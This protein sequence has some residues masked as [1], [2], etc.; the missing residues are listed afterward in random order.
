MIKLLK[1]SFKLLLSIISIL[2]LS[3]ILLLG[4]HSGTQWL[5]N[6]AES[7]TDG[8]LT[9]QQMQGHL[10]GDFQ[11]TDLN[12]KDQ[13]IELRIN[14]LLFSWQPKKLLQG[15]VSVEQLIVASVYFEQHAAAK[16]EAEKKVE[17][18]EKFAFSDIV[19]PVDISL[20][21]IKISDI[22]I[23]AA[24]DAEPVLIDLLALKADAKDST[25]NIH[26]IDIQAPDISF[27]TKGEVSLVDNYPIA[28]N[29][30]FSSNLQELPKISLAGM[31]DGNFDKLTIK[32]SLQGEL[33]GQIN[34][35]LQQL[36]S[37]LSADI[38]IDISGN[39][40]YEQI[41]LLISGQVDQQLDL[42]WNITAPQL[43]L[44][45][46]TIEGGL[47]AEGSV[48]G[49]Q[50]SP[51][52]QGLVS[53][54]K[55]SIDNNKL[56]KARLDFTLSA[57]RNYAN[58]LKLS[59][60]S[61]SSGENQIKDLLLTL[62]GT[63]EQHKL[64]LKSLLLDNQLLLEVEG[65]L[66]DAEQAKWQGTINQI[67][68][69]GRALGQWQQKEKTALMIAADKIHMDK[70][71]LSDRQ[72]L[73]CTHGQ[74]DPQQSRAK[75][76]LTNVNLSRFKDFLPK[77]IDEL[78]G[79][80]NVDADV[81]MQEHLIANVDIDIKPGV[82]SYMIEAHKRIRL[83]HKNTKISAIYND[84]TAKVKW[85][86]SLGKHSFTG[87]VSTLR[88]AVDKDINTA[89][90]N[91]NINLDI[92]ELSLISALV[93]EVSKA[94]GFIDADLKLAG[95]ISDPLISGAV[96]FVSKEISIPLAGIK[97][98][99]IKLNILPKTNKQID[100][101][102]QIYS[103]KQ[104]LA[105]NGSA[106]LDEAENWPAKINIKGSNFQ[107]INLPD[108]QALISTDINILHGKEGITIKGKL[109]VPRAGIYL[110]DLPEGTQSASD[111][112]I[113]V[114]KGKPVEKE[115]K[116][117]TNMNLDLAIK[118]G[119]KVHVKAFGLETHL[120]GE[121]DIKQEPGQLM[122]ANGEITTVDGTFR[123]Y[124]QDLIIE[125]GRI[126]YAGGFIDDPGLSIKAGKDIDNTSVGVMV[127]G[128]AKNILFDTYSSDP[129]LSS[130]DISSL[131]ITGQK[132]DASGS[133][134]IYAGTEL[135]KNL[136]V[137]VNLG[138]ETGSEAVV[139]YTLGEKMHFEGTSTSEKSSGE[140]IYTIEVE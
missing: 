24:V 45:V 60:D 115:P 23:I 76:Q 121:I 107:L 65:A 9:Y 96:K 12:Y 129:N 123:A 134:Q 128:S 82:F 103:G 132:F 38:A 6:T 27:S 72:S 47:S 62:D 14:H 87:N 49:T 64:V 4:T 54:D 59:I 136:S 131:L 32:Q 31:I 74:W 67:R 19:L 126:F 61:I 125:Q 85:N 135:S 73:L 137:G 99:N 16:K 5:L 112:V 17:T 11:I 120:E 2:F 46:P 10:L 22:R 52:L 89:P 1:I 111:D 100:I 63:I 113:I 118:L 108:I 83:K 34:L 68:V 26:H 41:K 130:K 101:D 94:E 133:A 102:G 35:S 28:I 50:H 93:P 77:E 78:S 8:A 139:R 90:L 79:E 122:T 70:L 86:L 104:K 30:D 43:K 138:G 80:L 114:S 75:L 56:N 127:S 42:K 116:A 21:E 66:I 92:K 3:I 119:N 57:E 98:T 95:N 44:L 18:D 81:S 69:K 55:I 13:A 58:N 88:S 29:T 15:N 37:N 105:I 91:G 106:A 33:E 109:S 124:G 84:T 110:T 140:L 51:V 117:A 7:F 48:S 25:I 39:G 71:C 40:P 20:N 36:L 53:L 97:Y